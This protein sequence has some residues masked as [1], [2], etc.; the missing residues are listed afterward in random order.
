MRTWLENDAAFDAA[1]EEA[2]GPEHAWQRLLEENRC[3]CRHRPPSGQ[4]SSTS[5][6]KGKLEQDRR[7]C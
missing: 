4:P 2:G 3:D 6:D 1:K 5:W 7:W